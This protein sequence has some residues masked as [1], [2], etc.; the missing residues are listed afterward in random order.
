MMTRPDSPWIVWLLA[1]GCLF[2]V[3]DA[4]GVS[5]AEDDL[6]AGFVAPP[7]AARP[8]TYWLWLNGYVNRDYLETELSAFRRAG[9]SSLCLF[10]M[11]ARGDS[12]GQPPAGPAFMSDAWLDQLVDTMAIADRLDLEIGLSVTSSWDMGGAWVEPRHA[13]MGLFQ[14]ETTVE[15]PQEL[16]VALPFPKLP[17]QAPRNAEGEPVFWKSVAVLAVPADRRLPG[18]EFVFRLDPAGEHVLDHVVLYNATFEED[19]S[20]SAYSTDFSLAVSTTSPDREAFRRVFRGTLAAKSGPQRFDLPGPKARFVRLTILGSERPDFDRAALAEFQVFNTEGVNLVASHAADR[21]RDGGE[22]L[23]I[24]SA[25]GSDRTWT[26]GNLHDGALS[27][28]GGCWASSGPPPVVVPAPERIVDLTRRVDDRGR[29]RWDVPPGRWVIQ[30][31]VC[32]NTGERLKVPSPH[33]DGLATDHFSR[34]AT[35]AYLGHLVHRLQTRF[36]DLAETPLTTLYLASYEVRQAIWTPRMPEEF[37]RYRGYELTPYLPALS[38]GIVGDDQTTARFL[39]DFRKTLGDLLVDAYYATAVEVAHEA[40]LKI[41]S[42]AGGPGPPIH[43]VPADALKALGAIDEVRGEF[44]PKRPS[45][46]ALWVVK[47]TACAAHIYGKRRVHMEAFTSMHHWQDGPI[48]LKPA[49]DRAF[50]EGANH[51]VWHT[52]SHQPPE[53]GLPGWVY[54]AGTH[55][56][57]NLAWWPMADA[58]LDYLARCSYLLQRGL[59][60]ADVCYY[61]GDQAF[62]FVPPRHT[63]P[64]LGPGFDYDVTNREVIIGRMTVEHGRLRLP[65]GMSYALLVLPERDDIDLDVLRKLRELVD[66]GATVVGPRPRRATGL[67]GQPETDAEVREIADKLW[68]DCDGETVT[69]HR[70]GQGRIV[71]GE[72]LRDVLAGQGIGPDFRVEPDS[73][74]DALGYVHRRSESADI[75]FVRNKLD[76]CVAAEVTF[77]VTGMAPQRWDPAS[78]AADP[79]FQYAF[80]SHGTRVKIQLAPLEST[81]IVFQHGDPPPPG[82]SVERA[83]G[84]ADVPAADARFPRVTQWDQSRAEFLLDRPGEYVLTT[85][86]GRNAVVA[87]DQAMPPRELSGPW[88]VRFQPDRGAPPEV[89]FDTLTPWNEHPEPAVRHFSGMATYKKEFEIDADWC[90]SDRRILLDLGELWAI[91]RVEIDGRPVGV[92]WKPPYQ[93]EV[94]D[95]LTPGRHVLEVAVA[96][97][98]SNRL[99][100]DAGLPKEERLTR[101]NITH[102]GGVPWSKV[103]LLRSGLFGPVRLLPVH[104]VQVHVPQQAP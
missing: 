13:A 21:T 98:W 52:A 4:V 79:L 19:G 50:W 48:D 7:D 62:N 24:P 14:S 71:W 46:D 22:L 27:G 9:V 80:T 32:G 5:A 91:A 68:G 82:I 54:G 28:P 60:V 42:E 87:V 8:G 44:W 95:H 66:A 20:G 76:R 45:A 49:A 72:P 59:H 84:E 25:F 41:E 38:G 37:R 88:A 93:L 43:Q 99:V 101:T 67:T 77:R 73:A 83:N 70:Y 2:V 6:H 12:T 53:A 64:Q 69:Q 92:L 58:F 15:G 103:P 63:D 104:A 33:S 11:G 85:T 94:T 39:Y 81:F 56:G 100:G 17:V 75:Y 18:H 61:Y 10:D 34:E 97:T 57:P 55:L 35:R 1:A 86:D 23:N 90:A 78:G 29:L 47:E 89:V 26:A 3:S 30:W 102:T 40:G 31:Y 36:P 74:C 96:N 16:D 51:F 65:D